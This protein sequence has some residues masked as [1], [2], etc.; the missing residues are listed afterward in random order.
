MDIDDYAKDS[1]AKSNPHMLSHVIEII[2]A[3]FPHLDSD[4]QQSVELI[5]KTGELMDALQTYRH[6]SSVTMFSLQKQNIDIEALLTSVRDVCY[7]REKSLIDTILNI[8]KAKNLYETYTAFASTMASQSENA[9]N[10]D[11]TPGG[12][13]NPDMMEILGALLTPEQKSTFDD[14]SSMFNT[15]Q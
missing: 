1:A 12:I 14:I 15:T 2:K 4:T 11:G 8:I 6:R 13:G 9:D 7:E 5:V 10:P 3:A